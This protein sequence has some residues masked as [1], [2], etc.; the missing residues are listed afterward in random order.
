M[1]N[2][3]LKGGGVLAFCLGAL[4]CASTESS[5]WR[6]SG[7][8]L[9]PYVLVLGTAQDGGQPQVGCECER[10]EDAREQPRTRRL[11][12]SLL[13]ADPAS[14]TRYLF[15]ASPDLVEQVAAAK[16][17]PLSYV[18]EQAPGAR[19]RLFDKIFLTHA[20]MGHYSGLLHLG[21]EAYGTQGQ[22]L[23]GTRNLGSFFNL[24]SPWK[25]M[26]EDGTFVFHELG[27]QR[28]MELGS[29][30]RVRA[31]RVPHRDEYSDT[32]CFV[33]ESQSASLAYLPDIDKWDVW[34]PGKI[35]ALIESVD[36]ALI[37]G[38]FFRDGEIPGRAMQEIPHPFIEESMARFSKLPESTR[39]KIFF[40]HFNHT[41][42][43]S[44]HGSPQSQEVENAGYG[45]AREGMIFEL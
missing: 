3:N 25:D 21:R 4:S 16:G 11:V 27:D 44:T 2:G 39:R 33:I 7:E 35:E 24:N 1:R 32:V 12:T 30:L 31:A 10:C 29:G 17:H 40:T 45:I 5:E 22:P 23:V 14:G 36:Y 34:G 41:N 18:G 26:L 20:H 28:A 9:A 13:L 42:P 19:P 6:R 37:D 38:T 15:D 43:V 8:E